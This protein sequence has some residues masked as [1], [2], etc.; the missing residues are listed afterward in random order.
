MISDAEDSPGALML[1]M[2]L[3]F[4]FEVNITIDCLIWQNFVFWPKIYP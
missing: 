3:N 4:I 1:T 2:P